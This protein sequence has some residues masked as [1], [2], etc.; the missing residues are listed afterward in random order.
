MVLVAP[1]LH[2]P[3]LHGFP[4]AV[5]SGDP[6][7][8]ASHMPHVKSGGV[9]IA[10]QLVSEVL[11]AAGEALPRHESLWQ[12]LKIGVCRYLLC[13]ANVATRPF[14]LG[15]ALRVVHALFV[16]HRH[17]LVLQV[18]AVVLAVSCHAMSSC[19]CRT[20]SSFYLHRLRH[21]SRISLLHFWIASQPLPLGIAPLRVS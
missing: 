21:F 9:L 11:D 3:I 8:L 18:R 16:L 20:L 13:Y 1:P 5:S 10:L 17:K 15:S 12:L 19:A 6:F 7:V 14:L 2:A 4:D